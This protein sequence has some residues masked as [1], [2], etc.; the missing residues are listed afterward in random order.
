M[1]HI[2]YEEWLDYVQD[3]VDEE[4]RLIYEDHLKSCDGCH[5]SYLKAVEA[6]AEELPVLDA[7]FTE[8]ILTHITD[9]V[10]PSQTEKQN[11]SVFQ[12]K[13]FHY[14]IAAGLTI[15]LMTSGLFGHLSQLAGDLEDQ[16]ITEQQ[17]SITEKLMDKTLYLIQIYEQFNKEVN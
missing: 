14:L 3:K 8:R 6:S 11:Q 15:L 16:S 17:P 13:L 9:H 4:A 1:R 7:D 10:K 5:L 2:E 12:K